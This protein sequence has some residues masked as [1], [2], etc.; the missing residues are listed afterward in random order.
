[1]AKKRREVQLE[2]KA[3][4]KN[5]TPKTTKTKKT[6]KRTHAKRFSVGFLIVLLL[7]IGA[8]AYFFYTQLVVPTRESERP[9]SILMVGSDVSEFR[10]DYFM[11]TK[12]EKTDAL[13][14]LTFNPN[15]YTVDMTSIPR[16]TSVDYVCDSIQDY[17]GNEWIYDSYQDQINELYQVSGHNM[18]CLTDSV[19]N[20]LNI[21][22]DYYVK[23]NMDQLAGIIDAVGGVEIEV[24]APDYYL[25]QENASLTTTYYWTDGEVVEMDGDQALT[26]A[27]A[28]HDSE[29]DYGRG[30]RQ[31][32]VLTEISSQV[33]NA[34]MNLDLVDSIFSLVE[35]D[36]PLKLIYEYY[37]Y[38]MALKDVID[39][40]G[41]DSEVSVDDLPD[42]V[43][44]NLYDLTGFEGTL[45]GTQRSRE[46]EIE[47]FVEYLQSGAV[48]ADELKSE[49][50]KNHQ[51]YNSAYSGHYNVDYDQLYEVSNELRSNLE[52]EEEDVTLPSLEYG[53]NYAYGLMPSETT[54][55]KQGLV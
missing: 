6:S 11:G 24:Y 49:M 31:Q 19:A 12:P 52:L 34:G 45:V 5:K 18:D 1:M 51:L 15:T 17:Y 55:A 41:G 46:K 30:I 4:K 42:S 33:L 20:F 29:K 10:D 35:T 8:G 26:Y 50:M 44:L 22:I 43:W 32:Q 39:M 37:K 40:I 25:S 7:L 23:V 28:R 16:D 53:D 2:K 21:P 13:I 36:M 38:V 3:A 47:E 9:L 48:D 14:V 54:L 27:R